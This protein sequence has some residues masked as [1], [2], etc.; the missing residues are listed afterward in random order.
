VLA[1]VLGDL[2]RQVARLVADGRIRDPQRGVDFRQGA[3]ELDVDDGPD[4]LKNSSIALL[5]AGRLHFAFLIPN[6]LEP[7]GIVP[8][9]DG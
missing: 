3:V 2:D 9:R 8:G 5:A 4:D 6:L 7:T 1:Q